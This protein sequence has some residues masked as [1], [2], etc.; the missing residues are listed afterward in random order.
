MNPATIVRILNNSNIVGFAAKTNLSTQHPIN[1][2]LDIFQ[3]G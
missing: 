2:F 1:M 3:A